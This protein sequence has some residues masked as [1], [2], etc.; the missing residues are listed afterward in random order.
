MNRTQYVEESAPA[1]FAWRLFG[2]GVNLTSS[3][4]L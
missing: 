2:C 4:P 1:H 3:P